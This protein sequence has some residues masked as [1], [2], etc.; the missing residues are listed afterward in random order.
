MDQE[1]K[2]HVM[3]PYQSF[4]GQFLGHSTGGISRGIWE[5]AVVVVGI[6]TRGCCRLRI[7]EPGLTARSDLGRIDGRPYDVHPPDFV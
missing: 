3:N 1:T 2:A 7:F 6:G 5:A 4:L